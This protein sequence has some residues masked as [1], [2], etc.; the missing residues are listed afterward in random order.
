M[1]RLFSILISSLLVT[2][3]VWAS[4]DEV[5]I[6]SYASQLRVVNNGVVDGNRNV[7]IK[8]TVMAPITSY[9]VYVN[10]NKNESFGDSGDYIY[11]KTGEIA[12]NT[13][14][15]ANLT[16]PNNTSVGQYQWAVEVV[17]KKTEIGGSTLRVARDYENSDNRYRFTKALDVVVDNSYESDYFGYSYVSE[18]YTHDLYKPSTPSDGDLRRTASTDG[19]YMFK[20]TMATVWNKNAAGT[21]LVNNGAYTGGIIWTSDDQASHAQDQREH[22]PYR[23]ATDED[24]Y[25]YVCENRPSK[26]GGQL[27][28]RMDP[29]SPKSN[30]KVI[31]KQS[32]LNSYS[33]LAKRAQSIAVSTVNG[34]KVLYVILSYVTTSDE[35][36]SAV[37]VGPNLMNN[38]SRL[39]SFT[40]NEDG[41]NVTVTYNNDATPL[42]DIP[43]ASPSQKLAIVST[44]NSMVAGVHGDL[45]IFQYVGS[46]ANSKYAGTLHLYKDGNT[47]KCDKAIPVTQYFNVRGV[48]AITKDGSILAIP[49]SDFSVKFFDIKYTAD[50]KLKSYTAKDWTLPGQRESG[51]TSG[52]GIWDQAVGTSSVSAPNAIDGLAFDVANNLYIIAG[53]GDLRLTNANYTRSRLYVYACP[54]SENKHLTPASS[55]QTIKVSDNICWHPYPDSYSMTN[56]DLFEMFKR[57]Y[58]AR[59]DRDCDFSSDTYSSEFMDMLTNA[60]SQWKWLGEFF[61]T[62]GAQRRKIPTNAELW[63]EFKPYYNTYYGLSRADQPITDVATFAPAR[64]QDIMTKTDSKYKWLGDYIIGVAGQ[65]SG[66]SAWRWHVHAFFNCTD[67]TV[68]GKQLVATANFSSAGKPEYW[69]AAYLAGMKAQGVEVTIN[70]NPI[71]QASE[72]RVCAGTFFGQLPTETSQGF[73]T[74]KIYNKREHEHWYSLWLASLPET[75][76]AVKANGFPVPMRKDHVF[77]G[78]YYGTKCE[79]GTKAYDIYSPANTDIEYACVYARW[80]ETCLHEGEVIDPQMSQKQQATYRNFNIDLINLLAGQEVAIKI[81]R[82]LVGGMYNTMCLPFDI[83]GREAFS[84][85]VYADDS[86]S[87]FAKEV[88]GEYPFSLVKYV[89]TQAGENELILDFDE[90][91]DTET[92]HANT[93]FLLMPNTNITKILKYGAARIIGGGA[94]PASDE[95]D[96]EEGSNITGQNYGKTVGEDDEYFTYT[97]VLAPTTIPD[98]SVLLVADNRLAQSTG[99]EMKGMRGF[100]TAK[101]QPLQMPA[102]VRIT[103][104]DGVTTYLDA[105]HT[106]NTSKIATKILHNGQ[107]YILRGNEVYTITGNRVR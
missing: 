61:T 49:Q 96:N 7:S 101:I 9:K 98:G 72:W 53:D 43:C 38:A 75:P 74:T 25:V 47:W 71:D 3:S 57:D 10:L 18:S 88:G 84:Q 27:V 15:T 20:P 102:V 28:Y 73:V 62:V 79:T 30:F 105:A 42:Y 107:I 45:W 80:I 87:P 94:Q 41:D 59:Y 86:G 70:N 106:N 14:V 2:T 44:Y 40:I 19:I 65:L 56:E 55:S 17:G 68:Q 77:A 37:Y 69:R 81:D 103:S 52:T 26:D 91:G 35:A 83:E 6:N 60:N 95:G 32:D 66:E 97:G 29:H 51:A 24:G 16:L 12:G 11:S 89:G 21:E 93:P 1:K 50:G 78:W 58:K 54:I 8:F 104:R 23:M 22:G 36:T 64:M 85:I 63:E 5:N 76:E 46:T 13:T 100:F 99:G 4:V 67:G 48:G 92:L 39:C 33:Q 31:L 90:L 34:K 82:K